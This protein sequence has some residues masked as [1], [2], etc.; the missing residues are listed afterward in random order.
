[1]FEFQTDVG[2]ASS[3]T[4]GGS[5]GSGRL[6]VVYTNLESLKGFSERE[7]EL[8]DSDPDHGRWEEQLEMEG[9]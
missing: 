5:V 8:R 1:M 7:G 3:R 2:N 6:H 4:D 9:E